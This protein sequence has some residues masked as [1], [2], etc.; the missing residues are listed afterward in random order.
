MTALATHPEELRAASRALRQARSDLDDLERRLARVGQVAAAG[1]QGTAALAHQAALQRTRTAVQL[2]AAPVTELA[3]A[4]AELAQVGEEA[5]ATVRAA[6]DR[7]DRAEAERRI[8]LRTLAEGDPDPS[9][10]ERL[11]LLDRVLEQA[12][13]ESRRAED[14]LAR[15]RQLVERVMRSSWPLFGVDDLGDLIDA[16][17]D[18]LPLWRGSTLVLVGSRILLVQRQLRGPLAPVTRLV[19]ERRLADLMRLVAR[20]PFVFLLTGAPARILIPVLVIK[21]AW[22]DV[23]D[24]GGYDGHRGVAIR[25]TAAIAIPGSVA[26]MS[27]HPGVAAVGALTVG[28]Y[29]LTKA[30]NGVVDHRQL[31]TRVVVTTWR[32]RDEIGRRVRRVIAPV[33]AP[34]GE[35]APLLRAPLGPFGPARMISAGAGDLLDQL[36]HLPEHLRQ[37]APIVGRPLIPD[38]VPIPSGPRLPVIPTPT[39]VGA[40]GIGIALPK[41]GRLFGG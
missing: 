38:Q 41:I 16:G 37:L 18:I 8:L 35:L 1:W 22:P 40:I 3:Q 39:T 27:P 6:Q 17:T 33:V 28:T 29:Y 11:R 13:E 26:M 2:R 14:R 31:L 32:N 5:R 10:L 23:W 15:A 30:G 19:L 25:I 20:P 24:G 36:P 4:M 12:A 7:R 21:D 9:T 34:S